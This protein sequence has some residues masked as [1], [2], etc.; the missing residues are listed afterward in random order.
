[1]LTTFRTKLTEKK[2]LVNNVYIYYFDLIEPQQLDFIAGQ[3][4]MLK[5][6]KDTGFVSRLYSV[7]SSPTLKNKLELVVEIIPNGLGSTYLDNLSIGQ[8][9]QFTGPGGV[10]VINNSE[11]KKIFMVTGTGIA[12]V[13][14]MLLSGMNNHELFWGL[15][16]FSEVYLFDE[17]KK[18]NPTI[19]LSRE[20]SLDVIPDENKKYFD[21]GHV[22]SCFE[23]RFGAMSENELNDL[24]FYLCGGREV[25]ESLRVGLLAKNVARENIHFEKF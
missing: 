21:L 1:M 22:D 23:K 20:K 7:A 25:V 17:I 10:F 9:V 16:T 24:E 5:V 8:E 19:C 12:P 3:Y 15:K 11:R 14:S 4:L 6:P 2:L 13:R 18:F